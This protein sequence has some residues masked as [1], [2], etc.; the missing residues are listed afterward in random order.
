MATPAQSAPPSLESRPSAADQAR[1]IA[2][3]PGP[4]LRPLFRI[5]ERWKLS[6]EQTMGLIGV[7]TPSVYS[8]WKKD[9]DSARLKPFMIERI[10]HV[11][12]IWESLNVLLPEPGADEWVHRA[13]EAPLF[14]GRPAIE[15]MSSVLTTDLVAVR[16]YL[17]GERFR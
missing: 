7:D 6:R 13:N 15:L 8:G 11:L 4:V 14:G 12:A 17:D 16:R 9:P 10:S 2:A 5:T 3:D 1:R